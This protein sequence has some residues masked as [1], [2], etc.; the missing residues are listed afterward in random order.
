VNEPSKDFEKNTVLSRR[1]L[2]R[3]E[4]SLSFMRVLCTPDDSRLEFSSHDREK[5]FCCLSSWI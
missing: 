2:S 3:E 5:Q 1:G 4:L